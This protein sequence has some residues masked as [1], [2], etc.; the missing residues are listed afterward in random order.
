MADNAE[1]DFMNEV[2]EQGTIVAKREGNGF[3]LLT[4]ATDLTPV[5]ASGERVWKRNF[6]HAMFTGEAAEKAK[7]FK[8][9]DVVTVK[10]YAQTRKGKLGDKEAFLFSFKAEE[11]EEAPKVFISENVSG[12]GKVY[13][14]ELNEVRLAGKVVECRIVSNNIISVRLQTATKNGQPRYLDATYRTSVREFTSQI[15]PGDYVYLIGQIQTREP[16]QNKPRRTEWLTAKEIIKA[17]VERKKDND[18]QK[19]ES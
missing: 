3:T 18:V 11:I 4:L 8:V 15:L 7:Q 10:G 17:T 19:N 1:F 16:D 9:R 13:E 5:L 12:T 14:A 6:P 2:I